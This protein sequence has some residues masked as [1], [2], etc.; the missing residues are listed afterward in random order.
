MSTHNCCVYCQKKATVTEL[1]FDL[2]KSCKTNLSKT[3]PTQAKPK[4]AYGY[5]RVSTMQQNADPQSGLFI[6]TRQIVEYCFENNISCSG[7]Y[8][9]VHSAFNMRNTGL[10]GLHE[11]LQ[12]LGFS[13]YLPHKCRSKN[14]LVMSLRKAIRNSCELLLLKDED[15]DME[16]I[17]IQY[18]IVANIDRFGRDVKN[19]ISIKNQL[20]SHGVSIVSACQ[21]IR[22]G[23]DLG[24]MAFNQEAMISEMF[25]RDRSHRV[26]S[27]KQAK[28]ALGNFMGGRARYGCRVEKVNGVRLVR[29]C[30]SEQKT[31]KEITDLKKRGYNTRQIALKLNKKKLTKRGSVWTA[32]S[33]ASVS[34]S[35]P[36]EMDVDVTD[37]KEDEDDEVVHTTNAM[38]DVSL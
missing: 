10:S 22:T 36:E 33:V 2:C 5:I 14:P 29:E 11:M 1:G 12:E 7:L 23:N 13:V 19:M 38:S 35:K 20:A 6:Q 27:V 21:K 9:D 30:A 34:D 3:R 28:K 18:I 17:D 26:K 15:T 16:D 32:H 25:S 24:E 37:D 8:Q 31:I 4:N